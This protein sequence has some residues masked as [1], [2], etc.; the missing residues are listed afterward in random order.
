MGTEL[1]LTKEIAKLQKEIESVRYGA[2]KYVIGVV[3]TLG[4]MMTHGF[5][6]I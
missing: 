3:I 5:H 4:G 6:W 1:R 2:L